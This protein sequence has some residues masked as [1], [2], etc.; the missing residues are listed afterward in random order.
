MTAVSAYRCARFAGQ[1]EVVEQVHCQ[2]GLGLPVEAP[3]HE[4]TA[5]PAQVLRVMRLPAFARRGGVRA[6]VGVAQRSDERAAVTAVPKKRN[7]YHEG[8]LWIR[9]RKSWMRFKQI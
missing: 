9:S 1:I 4:N 7:Q 5:D 8:S 3:G 6:D 2:C